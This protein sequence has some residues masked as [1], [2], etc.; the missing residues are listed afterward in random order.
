MTREFISKASDN[1]VCHSMGNGNFLVYEEG[2]NI[3]NVLSPYTSP[4]FFHLDVPED[5]IP[6]YTER[7]QYTDFFTHRHGNTVMWDFVPCDYVCVIREIETQEPFTLHLTFMDNTDSRLIDLFS[8][9]GYYTISYY[10]KEGSKILF[11]SSHTPFVGYILVSMENAELSR[12]NDR[13]WTIACKAGDTTLLM[14]GNNNYSATMEAVS[15]FLDKGAESLKNERLQFW[16]MYRNRRQYKNEPDYVDD[17]LIC[18]KTQQSVAGSLPSCNGLPYGYSRDNYG[19]SRAYLALGYYDDARKVLDNRFNKWRLFGNLHN[20]EGMGCIEPRHFSENEEVEQTSYTLLSARDYYEKTDDATYINMIFPMLLWCANAQL[21]YIHKDMLPHNGDETFIAGGLLR[22]SSINH[23]AAQSTLMFIEGVKWLLSFAKKNGRHRE[24]Y[25]LESVVE[26]VKKRYRDNFIL[27]GSYVANNPERL[28]GN[29]HCLPTNMGVCAQGDYLAKTLQ[30]H[31]EFFV[32]YLLH[33]GKGHY[34][35]D[36][37]MADGGYTGPEEP[38]KI[39]GE[40]LMTPCY[41]RSSLFTPTEMLAFAREYMKMDKHDR[42]TAGFEPA[43]L[44]YSLCVCGGENTE[45]ATAREWVMEYRNCIGSWD[46]YYINNESKTVCHRPWETG[47]SLEALLLC[48]G[49][50]NNT[51]MKD[52]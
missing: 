25:G 52:E 28:E 34:V 8:T 32:G 14:A 27:N 24:C 37:T 21:A 31:N 18:I 39:I 22:R 2:P 6:Y 15:A 33:D 26:R 43:L 13:E 49:F 41:F 19:A 42:I 30:A 12:I 3:V 47:Y 38:P 46:E 44:L 36:N 10:V 23:G 45:I 17:A 20:A 7:Q 51:N 29:L 40:T 48:D 4:T 5:G 16:L 35:K 9:K 1:A 11:N 50:L